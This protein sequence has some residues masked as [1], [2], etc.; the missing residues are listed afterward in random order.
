MEFSQDLIKRALDL[1]KMTVPG[2]DSKH[3]TGLGGAGE[4]RRKV[5]CASQVSVFLF[6][7]A[8]QGLMSKSQI[9]HLPRIATTHPSPP[10]RHYCNVKQAKHGCENTTKMRCGHRCYPGKETSKSKVK[11]QQLTQPPL[12]PQVQVLL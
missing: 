1:A 9:N 7:N 10:P 11:G 6:S 2:N 12:L 8:A 4:G 3:R 5:R